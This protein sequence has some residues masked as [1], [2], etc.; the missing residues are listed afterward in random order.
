MYLFHLTLPVKKIPR[1]RKGTENDEKDLQRHALLPY[2]EK[3]NSVGVSSSQ[4]VWYK[5]DKKNL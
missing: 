2:K 1:P 4:K 3:C 5:G